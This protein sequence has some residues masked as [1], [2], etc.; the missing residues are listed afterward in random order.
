MPRFRVALIPYN[1]LKEIDSANFKIWRDVEYRS[2]MEALND[3][4]EHYLVVKIER[5]EN[6]K[7]CI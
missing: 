2:A 4:E 5:I 6:G 3:L 1:R 7:N